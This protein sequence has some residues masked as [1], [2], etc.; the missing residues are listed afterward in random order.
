MKPNIISQTLRQGLVGNSTK[1]S[2]VQNFSLGGS[3]RF[4]AKKFALLIWYTWVNQAFYRH[5]ADYPCARMIN[6]IFR[7]FLQP[8]IAIWYLLCASS[9]EILS[10]SSSSLIPKNFN[11]RILKELSFFKSATGTFYWDNKLS[12]WGYFTYSY[13]KRFADT[14]SSIHLES[15]NILLTIYHSCSKLR[16]F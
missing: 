3:K 4:P 11:T 5:M 8:S 12:Y 2:N 1:L 7:T 14:L 9:S 13:C 6:R 15:I 10:S 16:L